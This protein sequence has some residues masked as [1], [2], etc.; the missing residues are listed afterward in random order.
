MVVPPIGGRKTLRSGRVTSSG[1]MPPVCSCESAPQVGFVEA[2]AFGDA[3]QIPDRI[4]RRLHHAHAAVRGNDVAVGADAPCRDR[5]ADFGHVDMGAGDRD[6]RPHVVAAHEVVAEGLADEMAPGIERHDLSWRRTIAGG[7]RC[8][9]P[10]RCRS[11]RRRDRAPAFAPQSP[12]RDRPNSRRHGF[13][14]RCG[15]SRLRKVAITGPR[16]AAVGAPHDQLRPLRP[17][18]HRR[19]ASHI[20][21]TRTHYPPLLTAV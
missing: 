3:G 11:D 1:Y 4:D 17:D 9:R 16:S 19:F 18:C 14:P 15:G 13:R 21:S 5:R 12:A 2:E 10:A 8:V 20:Y 7:V 6:G